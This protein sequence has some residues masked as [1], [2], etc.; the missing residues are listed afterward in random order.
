M[1]EGKFLYAC[2]TDNNAKDIYKYG[3]AGKEELG[4]KDTVLIGHSHMYV[5]QEIGEHNHTFSTSSTT[6]SLVS[7][8]LVKRISDDQKIITDISADG[9]ITE[10]TPDQ[11]NVDT[12]DVRY[13]SDH[14]RQKIK[15]DATHEHSGTTENRAIAFAGNTST[16]TS[17]ADGIVNVNTANK[18]ITGFNTNNPSKP[19]Y[20]TGS[21]IIAPEKGTDK[22][23]P[24]YLAVYM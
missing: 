21:T 12:V 11:N 15:L 23:M 19:T 16:A 22:N 17:S 24:P 1:I 6:K 14:R 3:Y 13:L 20:S 7:T 4:S 8:F 2:E 10:L 18:K 9:P 5:G